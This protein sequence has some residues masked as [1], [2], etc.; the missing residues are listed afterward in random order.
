MKLFVAIEIVQDYECI[1]NVNILGIYTTEAEA[2]NA[3]S[4]FGHY[5]EEWT[6]EIDTHCPARVEEKA[7][8]IY[9][10]R[11]GELL[12]RRNY[13]RRQRQ[14]RKEER[15]AQEKRLLSDILRAKKLLQ[16]HGLLDPNI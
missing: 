10:K 2:H 9:N 8:Y 5:V 3:P 12:G 4:I 6:G 7:T 16:S 1:E 15:I 13:L 11:R 14:Q